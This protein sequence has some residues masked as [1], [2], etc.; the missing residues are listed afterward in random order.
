MVSIIRKG[1]TEYWMLN[2]PVTIQT[3]IDFPRSWCMHGVV[4]TA[5][6]I[7]ETRERGRATLVRALP[8]GGNFRRF[9]SCA[10]NDLPGAGA[11]GGAWVCDSQDEPEDGK[12][13]Q[14]LSTWTI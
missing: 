1:R 7:S 14:I 8:I 9:Q 13:A 12:R 2:L 6:E 11:D 10:P 3:E 4:V 5:V